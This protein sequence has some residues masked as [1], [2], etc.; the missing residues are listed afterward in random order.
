VR[1]A[2]IAHQEEHLPG[3][4]IAIEGIEGAGKTTVAKAVAEFAETR[5]LRPLVL[6][7]PGT[8]ALGEEIRQIL[9]KGDER[10]SPLAETFLF[11]AA[12]RQLVDEFIIPA[13]QQARCVILDRFLLSTMAYQGAARRVGIDTVLA[14]GKIA[15]GDAA[16]RLT[17]LLDLPVEEG[18][19]RIA[20]SRAA[21]DKIESR[22]PEYHKAVRQ[23][24]LDAA[25][26]YP[27]PIVTIDASRPLEEVAKHVIEAVANVL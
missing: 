11:M 24:F 8:S 7:D 19:R 26:S 15:V 12:R 6:R 16:P 3:V 5:G 25:R 22:G 1:L 20:K 17:V 9:L 21:L 13:I 10:H 2:P 27:W 14:L 23:G 18:F 4:I